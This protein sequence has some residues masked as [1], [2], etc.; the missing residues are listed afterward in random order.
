MLPSF[1]NNPKNVHFLKLLFD[2]WKFI[3]GVGR[4]LRG[5]ILSLFATEINTD[6]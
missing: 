2:V 1:W 4:N 3:I 5:P 6:G